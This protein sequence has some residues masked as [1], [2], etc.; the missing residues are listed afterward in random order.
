MGLVQDNEEAGFFPVL[1]LFSEVGG[2]GPTRPISA[3][4]FKFLMAVGVV[5]TTTSSV[6]RMEDGDS[7]DGLL[8]TTRMF[9]V[10]LGSGIQRA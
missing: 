4:E 2:D 5:M 10:C 6:N 9:R 3:V 1:D 7:C 8:D